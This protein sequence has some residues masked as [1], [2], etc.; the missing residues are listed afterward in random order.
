MTLLSVGGAGGAGYYA[1]TLRSESSTLRDQVVT[2]EKDNERLSGALDEQ[3]ETSSALE[4]K[5]TA[6]EDTLPL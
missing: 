3:R 1:W 5:L 2:L 6:C 4:T